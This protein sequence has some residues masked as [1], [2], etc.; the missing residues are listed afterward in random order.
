M[1]LTGRVSTLGSSLL[2]NAAVQ[3]ARMRLASAQAS[4]SAGRHADLG[5]QL[6]ARAS[7]ASTWYA[8]IESASARVERL[9]LAAGRADATQS[10]LAA[11]SSQI[12][13]ALSSVAAAR[14]AANGREVAQTVA[15]EA[16][17]ALSSHLGTAYNGEFIFGGLNSQ[18]PPLAS[19]GGGAE[20]AI[21]GSFADTFGFSHDNPQ[22]ASVTPGEFR[23]YL[24]GA[25]QDQFD[26]GSWL[27]NWSAATSEV[28]TVRL[29]DGNATAASVSANGRPIRQLAQALTMIVEF[30]P[31]GL[32]EPSFEAMLDTSMKLLAE[33][34]AGIGQMQALTGLGEAAIAS[35]LSQT[36]REI[37]FL[38]RGLAEATAPDAYQLAAEINSLMTQLEASYSLT[39]RLRQL[40]L[41][42]Y[43]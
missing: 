20:A 12:S 29:A 6:G 34:Q 10:S 19:Y 1:M 30:S 4:L 39:G 17:E 2:T 33:A 35:S 22:A 37:G 42:N 26:D 3:Q 24:E 5:L 13:T 27:A 25:F 21:A 7:I 23:S 41:L 18:S 36:E 14:G 8:A 38:N 16:L 40:T 11:I 15:M 32:P 9:K 43:V 31:S 28:P